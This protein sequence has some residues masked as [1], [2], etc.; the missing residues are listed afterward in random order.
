MLSLLVFNFVANVPSLHAADAA[1]GPLVVPISSEVGFATAFVLLELLGLVLGC[2][3]LG[4]IAQQVRDGRV[5]PAR[6]A[7]AAAALPARSCWDCCCW[8]WA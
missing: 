4:V 2:V 3:Y 5:R 8:G 6:L 1:T 7:G